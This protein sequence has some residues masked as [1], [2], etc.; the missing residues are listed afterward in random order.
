MASTIYFVIPC[1]NEEEALPITAQILHQ[2]LSALQSA[3]AASSESRILFVDDGSKDRTWEKIKS[4]TQSDMLFAGVKL[5]HNRG[6]QNALLAGLMTARQYADA[7]ISMD[8]DLQDDI[9]VV[10]RFLEEYEGGCDV[11]YGVRSRREKDTFFKRTTAEG[12]YKFMRAMGVEMVFNH[13]DYR[14]MSKRALDALAEYREVNLFLRGIVPLIGFKSATVPYERKER[15]AGESKY[16]L[17]KMLA[18]AF[19]GITSF[20]I[21]PIRILTWLG[22]GILLVSVL[23]FIYVL[24]AHFSGWAVTGWSSLVCSIWLLGGIQLLALG[25]VGEY[26]GKIYAETKQRPRYWIENCLI[27]Q[28]GA[29]K[30]VQKGTDG[31]IYL[32]KQDGPPSPCFPFRMQK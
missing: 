19:D 23:A 10:D 7:V 6:H 2:K 4:F 16:P 14:L 22:L 21:K 24:I 30:S 32:N 28:N 26:I 25:V 3:G 12:F 8:A 15:V 17:K 20:S 5:S 11:V 27:K 29:A 9:D 31:A 1:Y 13:A 18:F